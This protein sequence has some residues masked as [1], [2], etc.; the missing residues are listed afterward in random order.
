M[1]APRVFGSL[2]YDRVFL[3][4]MTLKRLGISHESWLREP[5]TEKFKRC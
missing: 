3:I 2:D 4:M 5:F 1:G